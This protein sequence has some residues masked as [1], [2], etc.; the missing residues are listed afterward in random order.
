MT[1][2]E[3]AKNIK[4]ILYWYTTHSQSNFSIHLSAVFPALIINVLHADRYQ[5]N[6]LTDTP[7]FGWVWSSLPMFA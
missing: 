4:G 5:R 6:R 1:N 3:L 2:A 7:R